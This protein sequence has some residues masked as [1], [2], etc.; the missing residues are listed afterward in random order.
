[1]KQKCSFVTTTDDEPLLVKGKWKHR[2]PGKYFE[3]EESSS[4]EDG[5]NFMNLP[6][7]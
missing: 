3:N 1:M 5:E 7:L 4:N 2:R 6:L